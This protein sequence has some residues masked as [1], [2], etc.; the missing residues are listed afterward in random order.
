ML[1]ANSIIGYHRSKSWTKKWTRKKRNTIIGYPKEDKKL[2]GSKEFGRQTPL[3]NEVSRIPNFIIFINTLVIA[4]KQSLLWTLI[5][6]KQ[7][8]IFSNL[9]KK[10]NAEHEGLCLDKWI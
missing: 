6:K 3:E 10:K 5:N 7:T 8:F 4:W 1:T 2:G 9:Q